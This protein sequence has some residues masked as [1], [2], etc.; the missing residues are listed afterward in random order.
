MCA[1]KLRN[2]FHRRRIAWSFNAD[3]QPIGGAFDSREDALVSGCLLASYITFDLSPE[4]SL[5]RPAR[6]EEIDP[7]MAG[8]VGARV[9]AAARFQA[10]RGPSVGRAYRSRPCP[11]KC[12]CRR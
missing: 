1:S 4:L 2:G 5:R 6:P 12:N 8:R 7:G 11:A 9:S 3:H 10:M